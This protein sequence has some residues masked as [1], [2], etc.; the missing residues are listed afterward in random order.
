MEQE[1]N[2][3]ESFTKKYGDLKRKY[4]NQEITLSSA[5]P[6]MRKL[7]IGKRYLVLDIVMSS[8]KRY[9]IKAL[10]KDD[11]G[12]YFQHPIEYFDLENKPVESK[13]AILKFW[14]KI[15]LF[16]KDTDSL[17]QK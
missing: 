4:L 9:G 13:S 3:P 17:D 8:A 10:I 15:K 5:G 2:N 12:H 14:D 6:S 1:N 7:T 16:F 11:E